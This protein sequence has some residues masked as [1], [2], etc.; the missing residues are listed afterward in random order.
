ME[1][2]EPTIVIV[3]FSLINELHQLET[4]TVEDI[5][6]TFQIRVHYMCFDD[7]QQQHHFL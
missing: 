2:D 7:N 3:F 5:V 6:S 4:F 1:F